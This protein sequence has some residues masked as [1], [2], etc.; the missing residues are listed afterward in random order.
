MSL[1]DHLTPSEL[2][3]YEERAAIKEFDGQINQVEA[4]RQ[5]MR[6]TLAKRKPELFFPVLLSLIATSFF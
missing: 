2:E 4:E 5:A 6:E 1:I 3:D